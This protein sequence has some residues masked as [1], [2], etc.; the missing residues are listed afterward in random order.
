MSRKL[1]SFSVDVNLPDIG[2]W[3]RLSRVFLPTP[4]NVIFTLAIITL[5]VAA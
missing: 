5:L 1:F 4:G 3:P 2:T